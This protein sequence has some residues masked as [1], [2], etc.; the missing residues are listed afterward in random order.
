M[1]TDMVWNKWL[2]FIKIDKM[3]KIPFEFQGPIKVEPLKFLLG[4]VFYIK[5]RYKAKPKETQ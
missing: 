4:K 5:Y 2:G 1:N 3:D